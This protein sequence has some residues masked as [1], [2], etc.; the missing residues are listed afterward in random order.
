MSLAFHRRTAP[1]SAPKRSKFALNERTALT[2]P[3]RTGGSR[4]QQNRRRDSA[5]WPAAGFMKFRV[6]VPE[7]SRIGVNETRAGDIETDRRAN[8]FGSAPFARALAF[9]AT[10]A[11]NRLRQ[12]RF[13]LVAQSHD[14]RSKH[15]VSSI[16]TRTRLRARRLEGARPQPTAT[17]PVASASSIRP[18][19]T[20]AP[21]R[22]GSAAAAIH[23]GWARISRAI[24]R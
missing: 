24:R 2:P 22:L 18:P 17:V 3:D 14:F 10:R 21:F 8:P 6:G 20:R 11:R 13:G 7:T 23:S 16:P 15:A 5:P 9:S 1:V 12:R 19:R 4:G